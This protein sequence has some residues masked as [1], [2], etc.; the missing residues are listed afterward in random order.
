MV[1]NLTNE[2][3]YA[4]QIRAVSALGEG[5]PSNQIG[6]TPSAPVQSPRTIFVEATAIGAV[7]SISD[8]VTMIY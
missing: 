8:M 7:A 3:A 5:V 4:L 2:Q 1:R 6:V